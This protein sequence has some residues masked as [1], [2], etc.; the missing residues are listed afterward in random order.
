MA[1][2]DLALAAEPLPAAERPP[3]PPAGRANASRGAR[4]GGGR[5]LARLAVGLVAALVVAL[6][7]LLGR[8]PRA[9]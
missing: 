3:P 8:A 4:P 1:S 6:A 5:H 2:A 7:L 9:S